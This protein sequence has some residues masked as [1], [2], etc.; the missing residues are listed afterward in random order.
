MIEKRVAVNKEYLVLTS[1]EAI[2]SR[3]VGYSS[4]ITAKKVSTDGAG[5]EDK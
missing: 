3:I 2:Q 5:E 4:T 1:E